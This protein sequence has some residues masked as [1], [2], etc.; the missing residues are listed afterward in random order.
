MLKLPCAQVCVVVRI[1]IA[2]CCTPEEN[3]SSGDSPEAAKEE[4]SLRSKYAEVQNAVFH[5]LN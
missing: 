3:I 5:A 4:G 1:C 2:Q